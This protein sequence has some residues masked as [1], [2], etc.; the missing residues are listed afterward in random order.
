MHPRWSAGAGV[1]ERV[2]SV[3]VG[4]THPARRA[5][6]TAR[7]AARRP[8]ARAGRC[9]PR[10]RVG[11]QPGRAVR[12]P[13]ARAQRPA[14][15]RR[16]RRPRR[17]AAAYSAPPS[18]PAGGGAVGMAALDQ[19]DQRRL[20]GGE[21]SNSCSRRCAASAHR[22]LRAAQHQ[23]AEQRQLVGREA[24]ASSSRWR[25]FATREPRP[26]V[27]RVQPLPTCAERVPDCRLVAVDDGL[28]F[29]DWS[30]ASRNAFSDSGRRPRGA[31]LLDRQPSTRIS[32]ASGSMRGQTTRCFRC[33]GRPSDPG[34]VA[35]RSDGAPIRPDSSHC[36]PR[37]PSAAG[38]RD[39]PRRS[40]PSRRR[41]DRVHRR[42]RRP[43]RPR[44]RAALPRA[45]PERLPP[46]TTSGRRAS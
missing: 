40:R 8:R 10:R 3:R 38:V 22:R 20:D 26:L 9:G 42:P 19:P 4:L 30:H 12:T 13:W 32:T 1:L 36:S 28:R 5:A 14:R 16:R 24:S 31:L 34:A 35:F 25:Y 6:R 21:S 2:S 7:R 23:H 37:S 43:Q 33:V 45:L 29:V 15:R 17:P 11:A 46:T 39:G 44:P 27:R 41:A 18:A